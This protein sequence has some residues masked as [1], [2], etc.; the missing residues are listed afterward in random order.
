MDGQ[1]KICDKHEQYQL[2]STVV[3]SKFPSTYYHPSCDC[4]LYR[5][6]DADKYEYGDGMYG[7]FNRCNA[8]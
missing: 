4:T 8:A 1:W 5:R 6:F 3:I 2:L 7:K